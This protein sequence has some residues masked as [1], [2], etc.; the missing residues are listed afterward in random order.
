[1]KESGTSYRGASEEKV[2]AK[3]AAIHDAKASLNG[4]PDLGFVIYAIINC[5]IWILLGQAI[6]QQVRRI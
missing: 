1:M 5:F 6:I 4:L 3:S 2:D